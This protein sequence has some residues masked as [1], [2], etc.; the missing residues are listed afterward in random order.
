MRYFGMKY[1]YYPLDLM[2]QYECDSLADFFGE[3]FL[4]LVN[5][6]IAPD[7]AS[8]KAAVS[9]LFDVRMPYIMKIVGPRIAKGGW[10]VGNR[11]STADFY[12]GNI[13]ASISTNRDSYG[14]G[15]WA[16][17]LK[18]HPGFEAYGKRFCAEN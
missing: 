10:L 3:I 7:D 11:M 17:W 1:G 14:R 12:F 18:A 9:K 4:D 8:K 13:Y 6:F 5:P 15:E 16:E 2:Q